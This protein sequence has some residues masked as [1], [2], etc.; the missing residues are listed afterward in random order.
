VVKLPDKIDLKHAALLGVERLC[1]TFYDDPAW[2]EEMM[3]AEADFVIEMMRQITEVAVPHAFALWEDMAYNHAPLVS[4][5]MARR[6][7]LPRYKRVAEFLYSRGD[8]GL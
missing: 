5:D 4:P 7:M 3:D 6:F 1:M 2:L 8:L